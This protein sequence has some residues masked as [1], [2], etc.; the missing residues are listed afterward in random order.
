MN[1][2]EK[3]CRKCLGVVFQ[4]ETVGQMAYDL[5]RFRWRLRHRFGK[6]AAPELPRLH[7]GCG[8]VRVEGWLNVDLGGADLDVDLSAGRLPWA[9]DVFEAAVGNHVIEHL[10]LESEALPLLFELHRVIRPGGRI[11][12]GCPDMR[13][14]CRAYLE[15]GMASLVADR[16]RR[17]GNSGIGRLPDRYLLNDLFHQR[18]PRRSP[19]KNLFDFE[20]LRWALEQAGFA[21]VEEVDPAA[22]AR[23]YPEFPDRADGAQSIYVRAVKP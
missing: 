7:F 22:L 19:H 23:R 4:P 14:L 3:F 18:G 6:P 20:L 13:R 10:D 1:P 5:R 21:G 2:L 16:V 12:L 11:W 8:G 9:P 17:R 15:D